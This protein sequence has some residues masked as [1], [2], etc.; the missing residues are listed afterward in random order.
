M[1]SRVYLV[2]LVLFVT[3]LVTPSEW[4]LLCST[5]RLAATCNWY[6]KSDVVMSAGRK[7]RVDEE[8]EG[9]VASSA[10]AAGIDPSLLLAILIRESGD[11]HNF[12]WLADTPVALLHDF[13]VGISNMQHAA[14]DEA[15]AHAR[16]LIAYD[17]SFIRIDTASAI[18]AAAFLLAKRQDQLAPNRSANFSD[19]EYLRIGYRAG[20]AAMATAERTGTSTYGMELFRISY[21]AA[22]LRLGQL[23]L[24]TASLAHEHSCRGLVKRDTSSPTSAECVETRL[25]RRQGSPLSSED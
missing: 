7:L 17:W 14:F 19:V 4:Q 3:G 18:R 16:G 8:I 2:C 12:D 21:Q 10:E 9:L 22:R 6:A 11:D 5:S 13:S 23:A 25:G 15:K 20:Y 24:D 1:R